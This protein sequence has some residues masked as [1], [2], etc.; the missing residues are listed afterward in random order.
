MNPITVVF[1]HKTEVD[2]IDIVLLGP[3]VPEE[4]VLRLDVVVNVAFRMDVL[5]DVEDLE[6]QVEADFAG[7]QLLAGLEDLLQVVAEPVH[8][9]EA[10]LLVAVVVA[11]TA[12]VAGHAQRAQTFI[13]Q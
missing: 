9:E 4:Q 8:D 6:G 7:E 1:R 11:A 10:V 2:E 5:Q 12:T 13:L 3:A